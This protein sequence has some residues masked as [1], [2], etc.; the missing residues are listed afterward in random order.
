MSEADSRL[1]FISHASEDTWIA[2]QMAL[3]IEE[4]TAE[5]GVTVFIDELNLQ[6]GDRFRSEIQTALQTCE[7]MVVLLSPASYQT[8]WVLVEIGAVFGRDKRIT[9]VLDKLDLQDIPDVVSDR[10][11]LRLNEFN[12][13]IDQLY[14]RTKPRS[15][16]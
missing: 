11:A 5:N 10:V 4:R 1:V 9:V 2:T 13:F 15:T 12:T 14:S 6:G 7:E 16:S 8:D 3:A